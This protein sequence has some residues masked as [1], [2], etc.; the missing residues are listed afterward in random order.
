MRLSR[1]LNSL[2]GGMEIFNKYSAP[3]NFIVIF[4]LNIY[5]DEN[6]LASAIKNLQDRYEILNTVI[7]NPNEDFF[8]FIPRS[9][10]ETYNNF[11]VIQSEN[12]FSQTTKLLNKK[13]DSSKSLIEIIAVNT[14]NKKHCRLMAKFHHAV[15]DVTS[16]IQFLAN[17]LSEYEEIRKFGL[18]KDRMQNYFVPFLNVEDYFR[19]DDFKNN[20]ESEST[21]KPKIYTLKPE[22]HIPFNE[23]ISNFIKRI[24]DKDTTQKIILSCKHNKS[25]V[26]GAICASMLLSLAEKIR[27]Q[28][29]YIYLSCRSSIDL[30]RRLKPTISP[31]NLGV[32]TTGLTTLHQINQS[33]YFWDIAKEVTEK[34]HNPSQLLK[35]KKSIFTYKENAKKLLLNS[36]ISPFSVF[37]TNVGKINL[38]MDLIESYIKEISYALSIHPLLSTYAVSVSTFKQKMIFN[39]MYTEQLIG[40][41]KIEYL[42]NKS[43]EILLTAC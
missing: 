6:I 19:K 24:I 21:T 39:F 36:S 32:L 16:G 27:V 9:K 13:I 17:L 2:E 4:D 37:I 23:R 29:D 10:V 20:Y 5:L 40:K 26:H 35:V 22:N 41:Q 33:S 1:P 38:K 28:N 34:I 12:L 8:Y 15:A 31:N 18:H 25:T 7:V 42:V 43:I 30:R 3:L 14:T 11:E